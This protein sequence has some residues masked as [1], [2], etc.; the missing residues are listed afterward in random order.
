MIG[1][2]E[3]AR[4]FAPG[5]SARLAGYDRKTDDADLRPRKLGDFAA[6][7]VTACETPAAAL[8]EAEAVLSLVT[9]DQ[10]LAAA[11]ASDGLS[12]GAFWFDMNSV[13]PQTKH[14]AARVIT[15]RGGRYVDAAVMAPVHPKRSAVP[16]LLSGPHAAAGA[17]LLVEIGFAD[18]RVIAGDIGAAS[19]VKMLRSVMVKGIEALCAE[20]A[21][22]ADA[23][24]VLDEVV[25]SLD[26]SPPPLGWAERFDY[27]LDRMLV[28][29][30]RRAAEMDEVVSTL[31]ALGIG[32]TMS[33]GTVERQRALG[34]LAIAPPDGLAAKLHT[35]APF[36]RPAHG[37]RAA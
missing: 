9:A 10:A 1:F 17:A 27:N 21:L 36:V 34:A 18:V 32:A 8:A 19:A 7:G 4:A 33:R 5:L 13:A 23:A 26:A 28:H 3:A 30:L 2:G 35:L 14:S 31:E 12:P 16:I 22:A 20:C 11:T 29:G 24:G 6:D 15:A 37:I 25:A